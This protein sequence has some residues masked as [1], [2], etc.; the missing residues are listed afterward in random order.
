MR[1]R[2]R[3]GGEPVKTR[4]RKTVTPKRRNAPKVARRRNSAAG[5]T[6]K[7]H[8]LTRELDEAH[9]REV[10]TADVLKVISRSTFDL[11]AVLDTLV[12]SAT[13]LCDADRLPESGWPRRMAS[14][15]TSPATGFRRNIR[16]AW[17]AS[18]LNRTNLNRRPR[19]AQTRRPVHL[20][21]LAGRSAS[22]APNDH[23]REQRIFTSGVPTAARRR[24]DRRYRSSSAPKSGRSQISEIA[25]VKHSP[26][27]P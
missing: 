17:S 21:R 19:R 1:R 3:A 7:S 10:A 22:P 9:Q 27:R 24:S 14:T 23:D 2:S 26:T 25:L 15:I 8:V 16:S 5:L 11:Q 20:V 13:R 4:R 12:E 18:R 6:R